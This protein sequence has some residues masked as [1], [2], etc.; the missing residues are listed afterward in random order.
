MYWRGP[1]WKEHLF[2]RSQ[3]NIM[4]PSFIFRLTRKVMFQRNFFGKT[5][6]SERLEKENMIYRAVLSIY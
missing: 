3:E 4:F 6:F 1:F 2:R 5:I